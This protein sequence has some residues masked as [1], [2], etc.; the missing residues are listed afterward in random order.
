VL[1]STGEAASGLFDLSGA[2]TADEKHD[3]S[4]HWRNSR[5]QASRD[6]ASWKY[7]DSGNLVSNDIAPSD[8]GQL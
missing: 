8:H 1:R 2:S 5:T 4:R 3:L 6:P 7:H